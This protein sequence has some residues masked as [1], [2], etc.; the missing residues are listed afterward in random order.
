MVTKFFSESK[1]REIFTI[2]VFI[3][4]IDGVLEVLGAAF[5]LLTRPE[6]LSGL[7]AALTSHELFEEPND[8]IA[9]H[10][11]S[12]SQQLSTSTK[13]F[14]AM[15]LLLHGVIKIFLV[16]GLLKKKLWTYPLAMVFLAI[17]MTYQM[18]RYYYTHALSL[19]IL[20]VFDAI[21]LGLTWH[22]YNFI[23]K[24]HTPA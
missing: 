6:R 2:T 3:K 21:I 8:F 22:E 24:Q 10:L 13:F 18:Y 12:F 23:K 15:Y 9:S 11:V 1:I 7:I 4:G 17:F 19:I 14:E 16:W 20:T 5:L